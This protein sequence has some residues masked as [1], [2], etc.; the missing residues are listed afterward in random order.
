MYYPLNEYFKLFSDCSIV[1]GYRN[2]ILL[3]FTRPNK[4]NFVPKE[5][6]SFLNSCANK[7]VEDV[8]NHYNN[9]DKQV[10]IE[11]LDFMVENEFGFFVSDKLKNNFPTIN[12]NLK[13]SPEIIDNV[14]LEIDGNNLK[15]LKSIHSLIEK[16][17]VA[18]LEIRCLS[19][20]NQELE[21][22]ILSF[23]ASIVQS[24]NIYLKYIPN[25]M[26]LDD[27]EK[28]A[29]LNSRIKKFIAYGGDYNATSTINRD[30]QITSKKF[31]ENKI[32]RANIINLSYHIESLNVCTYRYK[33]LY[34][35]LNGDLKNHLSCDKVIGNIR[36]DKTEK[37]I[38]FFIEE[39][40]KNEN[41]FIKKSNIDV[42]RDCEFRTVCFT[43][44]LP[45]KNNQGGLYLETECTYN[46][47]IGK[48]VGEEGYKTLEDCG[49]ISN[50][51]GFKIDHEK[52]TLI[53]KELWEE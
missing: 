41:W 23:S 46:P 37:L 34:I 9:E 3:D 14:V 22:L 47:Y 40:S 24:I 45:L 8:L 31:N 26:Q 5:L 20:T 19:L 18:S 33:K 21:Q 49:V 1:T 51:K 39:H 16:C 32:V 28:I 10:A 13:K 17:L 4:S 12:T 38:E 29:T 7:T 53:N 6:L 15:H 52:I 27:L 48:A 35:S 50:E 25:S 2:A 36:T 44:N 43:N 11:Y 42:C 30:I